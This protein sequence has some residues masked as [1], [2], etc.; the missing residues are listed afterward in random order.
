MPKKKISQI[1]CNEVRD[2][3]FGL[4]SILIFSVFFISSFSLVFGIDTNTV[5]GADFFPQLF[6]GVGMGVG[7]LLV[8]TNAYK[9]YRIRRLE[10]E[11]TAETAEADDGKRADRAVNL[12]QYGKVA[13][14]IGLMFALIL[15]INYLGFIVGS[16]IYIFVQVMYLS[17]PEKRKSRKYILLIALV[18]IVLPVLLF[19]AFR[20]GFGILVPAGAFR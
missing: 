6:C 17:P 10:K 9:L 4:I 20:Y 7:A 16:C 8:L 1:W 14:C 18:S 15:M 2:I 5:I 13:G 19:V 11:K 12:K 3:V